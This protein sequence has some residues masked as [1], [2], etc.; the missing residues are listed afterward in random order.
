MYTD[1]EAV[2]QSDVT[3]LSSEDDPAATAAAAAAQAASAGQEAMC[4]NSY[5]I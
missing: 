2:A 1:T 3:P 4:L 5:I